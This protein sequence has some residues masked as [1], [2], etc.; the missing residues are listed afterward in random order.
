MKITHYTM[1]TITTCVETIVPDDADEKTIDYHARVAQTVSGYK[2]VSE[3]KETWYVIEDEEEVPKFG[4][5][6]HL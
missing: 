2:T 3:K 1:K 6:L 5:P 4:N